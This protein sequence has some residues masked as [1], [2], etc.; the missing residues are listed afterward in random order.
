MSQQALASVLGMVPS[1][2]VPLL[3]ELQGRGLLER[4]DHAEDR[5]L[6]ALYLTDRGMKTMADIGRVARSH[7]DDICGSLSVGERE[8]LATWLVRIAE[9]QKLRAG[10]HPGFAQAGD[11]KPKRGR[12]GE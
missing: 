8:Q 4:R 11:A 5:R 2:L 1:R 9:D 12:R 7:D 10:V 6:Y 3:D